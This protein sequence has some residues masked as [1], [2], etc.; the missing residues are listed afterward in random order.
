VSAALALL[1]FILLHAIAGQDPGVLTSTKDIGPFAAKGY[2]RALASIG[3]FVFPVIFIVGAVVGF[4]S[5]RRRKGL[6][7]TVASSDSQD[8]L[9]EM[10]WRE[11]ESLVE[12][13]FRLRGYSVRRLG[14]DGPDGGVDLVLDRGAERVLV[15]CK[16][17]RAYRVGVSVVRELS[18]S[19]LRRGRR[20]ASS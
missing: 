20:R 17:W 16:Q 4:I 10:T 3:Q 12:E 1:T 7:E 14:W 15:Q 8:A 19:W 2:M 6:I 18:A 13:A 9:A 11:F 5:K